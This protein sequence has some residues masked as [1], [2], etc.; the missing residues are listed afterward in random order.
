MA[1]ITPIRLD[2]QMLGQALQYKQGQDYHAM[3]QQHQQDME[4]ITADS[5]LVQHGS[6]IEAWNAQNRLAAR[7][8]MP[9]LSPTE[10][11]EMRPLLSSIEEAR[12]KGDMASMQAGIQ[13]VM[14]IAPPQVAQKWAT[15]IQAM[16]AQAGSQNLANQS[17]LTR[18]QTPQQQMQTGAAVNQNPG[19]ESKLAEGVV[20]QGQQQQASE[21]NKQALYAVQNAKKIVQDALPNHTKL[22]TMT[23]HWYQQVQEKNQHLDAKI[24]LIQATVKDSAIATRQI[25]ALTDKA[26][27]GMDTMPLQQEADKISISYMERLESLKTRSMTATDPAEMQAVAAQMEVYK[28]LKE[29]T[30]LQRRFLLTPS[31]ENFEAWQAKKN[32]QLG[33]G[34][35]LAMEEK[36]LMESGKMLA[37]PLPLAKQKDIQ[38]RVTEQAVQQAQQE[39]AS[40]LSQIDPDN[41]MAAQ[42]IMGN[43]SA[44]SRKYGVPVEKIQLKDKN[45]PLVNIQMPSDKATEAAEKDFMAEA[46]KKFGMLEDAPAQLENIEKSK[47]LISQAKSFMGPGGEM[48]LEGAKFL[49]NRL[50]LDVNTKGIQSAE[51]LRTRIFMNVLDNL[52]KM[53]AQPSQMQQIIMMESL[54]S[55]GTDPKAMAK[56]LDAYGDAIRLKVAR[57]N[58]KIGSFE[59]RGHKMPF[60]AKIELPS[61][62]KTMRAESGTEQTATGPHG[63]K[64]IKRNGKWEPMP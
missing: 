15:A 35:A 36:N 52:K 49:N 5:E 34:H 47:V 7:R 18:G 45:A 59:A 39:H 60:E 9:Q 12:T 26:T 25:K 10:F 48:L 11:T 29:M 51:E 42:R 8:S 17:G 14:R 3:V 2:S 28:G 27:A 16:Q 55:L 22:D 13:Q 58:A 50:G 1:E 33:Q 43:L 31:A 24:D 37:N 61:S 64:M 20:E 4:A 32:E 53:D 44:L 62:L 46:S 57:H 40:F 6:I 56:M 21:Q 38:S 30:D 41:K 63:E 23:Q 19:L 54:G